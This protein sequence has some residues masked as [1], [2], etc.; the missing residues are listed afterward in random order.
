MNPAKAGY[1]TI[2]AEVPMAEMSDFSTYMRQ[3]TQG[4]G[5][6]QFDFVRYEEAPAMVAQKVIEEA[7]AA[8][9]VE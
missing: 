3:V 4:R 2:D 1:Q 5:S 6:F 7:K 8:G 9:D